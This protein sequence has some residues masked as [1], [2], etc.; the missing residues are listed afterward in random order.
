MSLQIQREMVD[1]RLSL[2][3]TKAAQVLIGDLYCAKKEFREHLDR[4]KHEM[5]AAARAGDREAERRLREAQDE[6]RVQLEEADLAA[7]SMQTSLIEIHKKEEE[8]LLE[9]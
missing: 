3:E 6:F 8:R 1:E 2:D 4:V 7:R 9:N 5:Q